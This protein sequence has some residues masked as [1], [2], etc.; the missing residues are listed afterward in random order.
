MRW[1]FVLKAP[2]STVKKIIISFLFGT[3]WSFNRRNW[4][5]FK[6]DYFPEIIFL[7]R[8]QNFFFRKTKFCVSAR[9]GFSL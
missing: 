6:D 7:R 4:S 9:I 5:S 1:L 3:V 2:W 8:L